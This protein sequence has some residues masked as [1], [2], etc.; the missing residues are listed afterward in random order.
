MHATRTK[1]PRPKCIVSCW[2]NGI[3]SNLGPVYTYPDTF[4]SANFSF[5][6]Q[7]FISV[8]THPYS[9]RIWRP[10]VSATVAKICSFSKLEKYR[11]KYGKL[12]QNSNSTANQL[13]FSLD[14][15]NVKQKS[16]VSQTEYARRSETKTNTKPPL[17]IKYKLNEYARRSET[18]TNTKPP[19]SIKYKLKESSENQT[20]SN[21]EQSCASPSSHLRYDAFTQDRP[22]PSS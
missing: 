16:A 19:L 2:D 9:N 15:K 1:L 11:I 8:H 21:Y 18:K 10:H 6:I 3:K 4:E 13:Y 12:L 7:K 14:L 5:R 20:H 17:S 22:P